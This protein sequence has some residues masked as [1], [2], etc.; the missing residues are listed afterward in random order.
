MGS[1]EVGGCG[2]GRAGGA[3]RLEGLGRGQVRRESVPARLDQETP[4]G[5]SKD[6]EVPGTDRP[7]EGPHSSFGVQDQEPHWVGAQDG[8]FQE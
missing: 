2:F 1:P 3:L 4:P 6:E 7:E 8:S 5:G